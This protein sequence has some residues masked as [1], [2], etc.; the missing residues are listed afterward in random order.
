MAVPT[1]TV[2]AAFGVINA[3]DF[4]VGTSFVGGADVITTGYNAITSS[5]ELVTIRRGR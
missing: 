4:V 1:I 5:A 2:E 3:G